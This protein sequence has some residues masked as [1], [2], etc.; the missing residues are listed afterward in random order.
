LHLGNL[1]ER[2]N[3]G[4]GRITAEKNTTMDLKEGM[5][6]CAGLNWFMYVLKA[7]SFERII[8]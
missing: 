6:P 2:D 1:K 3:N 4:D 8:S 5:A 7:C